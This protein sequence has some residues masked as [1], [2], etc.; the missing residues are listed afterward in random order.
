[1]KESEIHTVKIIE[2]NE[3]E[4]QQ[5]TEQYNRNGRILKDIKEEL[6]MKMMATNYDEILTFRT[7][8]IIPLEWTE[9]MAILLNK[10]RIMIKSN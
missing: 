8:E 7:T 9:T 10:R 1:M 3:R 5:I 6:T 2:N 4:R